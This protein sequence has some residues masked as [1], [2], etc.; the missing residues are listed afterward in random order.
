MNV[1][2]LL[3]ESAVLDMWKD[4]EIVVL[5]EADTQEDA[6][7]VVSAED[8]HGGSRPMILRE[9]TDLEFVPNPDWTTLCMSSKTWEKAKGKDTIM[10]NTVF[11]KDNQDD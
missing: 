9:I 5:Y 8:V 10:W 11:S 4:G 7:G 6:E 2:E 1:K 3:I